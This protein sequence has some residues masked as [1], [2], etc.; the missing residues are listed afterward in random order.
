METRGAQAAARR[1]LALLLWAL[2]ALFALCLQAP[3]HAQTSAE[4]ADRALE[5]RLVGPFR[6]GRVTA[7]A[8]DPRQLH[9][10]YM[11]ATGGGVWKT[12]DAGATWKN[13]SDGFLHSGTIG[14]IAVAPANPDIVY[15]GTGEAPVR[16]VAAASGDGLY[17]STDAGRTWRHLG[18]PDSF[19]ISRLIVDPANPDRVW[20]AVQGDPWAPSDTRGVYRSDDGGETWRRL[21]FVDTHTGA[22]DLSMDAHDPNVLY[23]A[24]WDHQ[25]TP[26]NI[27]SGG[28]GSSLWKTADGGAHWSKLTAG[29]PGLMGRTGV[30]VSPA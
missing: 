28:P 23:A 24:M 21:L 29:L 25:R 13:I 19:Q 17:K 10:F 22:S 11:G 1:R 14:A 6:G 30:T 12:A 3:V 18:L 15:V 26:W 7:V 8:G 16:G 9:T 2:P 27:R 5:W 20:A 4:E